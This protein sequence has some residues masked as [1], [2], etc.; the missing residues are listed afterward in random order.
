[1]VLVER[2]GGIRIRLA[3]YDLDMSPNEALSRYAVRHEELCTDFVRAVLDQSERPDL[4]EKA[5]PTKNRF[6]EYLESGV[7]ERD[8]EELF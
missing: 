8:F 5:G 4:K 3:D 2:K 6:V 7:V 1:M